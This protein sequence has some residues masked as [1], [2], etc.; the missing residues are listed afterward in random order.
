MYFAVQGQASPCWLSSGYLDKWSKTKS[1]KEI[2]R[3]QKYQQ[4]RNN[5]RWDIFEDQC[6]I[7]KDD[8]DNGRWPLAKAYEDFSV[9]FE[10]PTLMELELSNQCNLECLMCSGILSSGIRKNRDKLPPL[11]IPYDDSF[12][13]QL[14]EF[15][16]YLEELRF[17]GGEPMLQNIVHKICNNVA[18]IKPELKINI[19]TNGT[20]YNKRV[21]TLLNK[22][23]IHLNISI[24]GFS[25]DVYEKIRINANHDTLMKHFDI[26]LRYCKDGKRE[27]SVMVNPMRNNWWEMHKFVEWTHKHNVNLWYNTIRYPEHL[28]LWNWEDKL[29]SVYDSMNLCLRQMP[30]FQNKDKYEHLVERQIKPWYEKMSV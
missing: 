28:A 22:C 23:N 21:Q 29:H 13:E 3:G 10:Y 14:N 11:E 9:D 30:N 6:T 5:L 1:I 18:K 17:N 25:K 8:I 7:C 4:Y 27:L 12:V 24:D 15:I 26:F 19:A 2:W 20:V 16:P